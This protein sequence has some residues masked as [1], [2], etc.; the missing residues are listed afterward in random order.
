MDSSD[1]TRSLATSRAESSSAR[2][3]PVLS[4]RARLLVDAAAA[5]DRPFTLYE[6]ADLLRLHAVLL[7]VPAEEVL[8][9]GL[10][11]TAGKN[12]VL[13]DTSRHE[14]L[15]ALPEPLRH[16]LET[17]ARSCLGRDSAA[18]PAAEV[19]WQPLTQ[20]EARVAQYVAKSKKNR[21]IARS[22]SVSLHTVESHLRNIFSKLGVPNRVALACWV[23][24][25]QSTVAGS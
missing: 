20:A 1:A 13:R 21:E 24:E 4:A 8:E 25:R 22:L 7:L 19:S 6:A 2:R 16:V 10:F 15:S 9:A 5:F 14:L 17:E 11:A 23:R 3:L 12:L 18:A